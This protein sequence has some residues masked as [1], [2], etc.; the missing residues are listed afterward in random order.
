LQVVSLADELVA[1][2]MP[3]A[4]LVTLSLSK[5]KNLCCLV[6]LNNSM[7]LS[8]AGGVLHLRS[9]LCACLQHR[10]AVST[11]CLLPAQWHGQHG[12]SRPVLQAAG[13]V[14]SQGILRH[15][16]NRKPVCCSAA[17]GMAALTQCKHI[18][19]LVLAAPYVSKGPLMAANTQVCV[20]LRARMFDL[21]HACMRTASAVRDSWLCCPWTFA[22]AEAVSHMG[23]CCASANCYCD[24]VADVTPLQAMVAMIAQLPSLTHLLLLPSQQTDPA[25]PGPAAALAAAA[26]VA[27][28]GLGAGQQGALRQRDWMLTDDSLRLVG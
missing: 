5:L 4:A 18:K 23:I 11:D 25:A 22:Q 12:L 21:M 10:L 3:F 7:A 9:S 15:G 2:D 20:G 13:E 19:Q 16:A 1:S 26:A 8:A 27:G 14:H 28:A 17:T 24:P 6:L